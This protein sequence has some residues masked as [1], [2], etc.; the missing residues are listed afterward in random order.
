MVN[1]NKASDSDRPE[2]QLVAD[3]EKITPRTA[4]RIATHRR[5]IEE[6]LAG[7]SKR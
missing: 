5:K 1:K 6:M 3:V 2:E 4:R 7:S